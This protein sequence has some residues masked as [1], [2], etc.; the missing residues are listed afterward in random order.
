[1]IDNSHWVKF[2]GSEIQLM[3]MSVFWVSAV[4]HSDSDQLI[5]LF[6]QWDGK[7]K[8]KC[9]DIC[10]NKWRNVMLDN[11]TV[12]RIPKAFHLTSILVLLL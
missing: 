5:P 12:Q 1:V 9:N 6:M 8:T 10:S 11:I 2:G 7:E 4:L 3:Y